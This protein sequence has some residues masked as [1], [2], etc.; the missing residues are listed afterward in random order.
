MG[1]G[2][3]RSRTRDQQHARATDDAVINEEESNDC[4]PEVSPSI[5]VEG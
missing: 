4:P 3:R 1:P 2:C 5:K